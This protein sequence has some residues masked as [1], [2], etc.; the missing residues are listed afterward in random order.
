MRD[1]LVAL[2]DAHGVPL[3]DD[4]PAKLPTT[5]APD[6][7][8]LDRGFA[9]AL[10]DDAPPAEVAVD[11]P[12]GVASA[13]APEDARA[14]EE[15]GAVAPLAPDLDLR[16]VMSGSRARSLI[17]SPGAVARAR[18][19]RRR[20]KAEPVPLSPAAPLSRALRSALSELDAGYPPA[21]PEEQRAAHLDFL[22]T[23]LC[24]PDLPTGWG[25]GD[26]R[27]AEPVPYGAASSRPADFPH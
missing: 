15:R 4:F 11:A 17:R 2:H 24:V 1:L 12:A 22:M 16:C 6:V 10:D 19:C 8:E 18:A 3:P 9:A 5:L 23:M 7:E 26:D 13:R 14:E 25:K 27:A 20:T 21:T